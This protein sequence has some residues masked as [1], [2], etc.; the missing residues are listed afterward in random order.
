MKPHLQVNNLLK[1]VQHFTFCTNLY[2]G[3]F[4]YICPLKLK[5]PQNPFKILK[6]N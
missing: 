3:L 1:N 6:F 2:Y 5:W 4:C